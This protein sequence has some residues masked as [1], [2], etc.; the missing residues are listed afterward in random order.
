MKKIL[1]FTVISAVF[2][3]VFFCVVILIIGGIIKWK[4]HRDE[5]NSIYN[6]PNHICV[7][8]S[9]YG[10]LYLFDI[11]TITGE[12]LY[13]AP[14]KGKNDEDPDVLWVERKLDS[15]YGHMT[16]EEFTNKMYKGVQGDLTWEQADSI[17]K[18]KDPT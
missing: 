13:I 16:K 4:E 10:R 5:M 8:D 9:V 18:S 17:N 2:S 14:Y 11:D 7:A 3:A 15:L 6:N 12:I 1:K